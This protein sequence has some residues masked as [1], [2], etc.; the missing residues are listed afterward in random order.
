VLVGGIEALGLIGAQLSLEGP[1]WS[2]IGSLN[3]HFARMGYLIIALFAASWLVSLAVYR[4]GRFDHRELT[5]LSSRT[6]GRR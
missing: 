3:D 6:S 1:F 5:V 2:F 4:L